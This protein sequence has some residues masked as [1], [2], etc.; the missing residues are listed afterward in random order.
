MVRIATASED[1]VS[2]ALALARE[3]LAREGRNDSLARRVKARMR[4]R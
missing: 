2:E 3:N 4:S 1:A